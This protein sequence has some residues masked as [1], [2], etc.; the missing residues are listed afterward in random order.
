M[1]PSLDKLSEIDKNLHAETKK[2]L[3]KLKQKP[4]KN[5]DTLMQTLHDEAFAQFDCL[6]CAHCCKTTGPLFTEADIG[7]I[8]K[9]LKMKVHDFETAYLHTDDD[10][11]KVLKQLP[12]PF[13]GADHYCSIYEFRPKACKE[14]PHTDRKKFYQINPLTLKNVAICPAAFAIVEKLKT[15]VEDKN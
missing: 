3:T 6:Q 10:G 12:C 14:Y 4:P 7:R 15:A 2:F 9:K 11:D 13:L 5:L 8:A 1:F